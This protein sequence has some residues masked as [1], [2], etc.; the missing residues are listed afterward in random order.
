MPVAADRPERP[1]RLLPDLSFREF[2]CFVPFVVGFVVC[3][4]GLCVGCVICACAQ[5]RLAL[6]RNHENRRAAGR[7]AATS[8]KARRLTA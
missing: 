8:M 4:A 5:D 2:H 1:L 7:L 6:A 3:L